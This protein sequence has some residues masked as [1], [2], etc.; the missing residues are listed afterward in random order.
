MAFIEAVDVV[1]FKASVDETVFSVVLDIITRRFENSEYELVLTYVTENYILSDSGCEN[2]GAKV[3]ADRAV[4]LR[5]KGFEVLAIS[6][7]KE[8]TAWQAAISKRQ[9]RWINYS[10]LNGWNGKIAKDYGVRLTPRMYLLDRGKRIIA[11]PASVEEL[12]E[13]IAPLTLVK[14]E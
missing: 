8:R 4:E 9:Y 1:L 14:T 10:E 3:S 7:D 12:K 6:I 5:D 2:S 11:K 13:T